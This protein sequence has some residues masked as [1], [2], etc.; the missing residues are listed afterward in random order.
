M[1]GQERD[2]AVLAACSE[3]ASK[4]KK[5]GFRVP[6]NYSDARMSDKIWHC[7]KRGV[8]IRVEIGAREIDQGVVTHTRRDV[9]RNSKRTDTLESFITML[10]DLIQSMHNQMLKKAREFMNE[11]IVEVA[12]L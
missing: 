2:G 6:W 9:G 12:T 4:I 7:I 10:P 1:K 5:A 8:P 11:N 3:L